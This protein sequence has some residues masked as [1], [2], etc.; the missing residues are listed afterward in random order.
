MGIFV[1]SIPDIGHS[2]SKY[3]KSVRTGRMRTHSCDMCVCIGVYVGCFVS[4]IVFCE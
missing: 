2:L 1:F 4:E 3:C